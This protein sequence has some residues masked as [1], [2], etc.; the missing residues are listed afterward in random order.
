MRFGISYPEGARPPKRRDG[1]RET[2]IA[3]IEW[4]DND[5][6][7]LNA[8]SLLLWFGGR[9]NQSR[10]VSRSISSAGDNWTRLI[11]AASLGER[12]RPTRDA[13]RTKQIPRDPDSVLARF[14]LKPIDTQGEEEPS[15]KEAGPRKPNGNCCIMMIIH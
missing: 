9:A 6:W 13:D 12:R 14:A 10:R 3:M 15:Q 4:A 7:D 2:T 11:V 8:R 5:N 1:G